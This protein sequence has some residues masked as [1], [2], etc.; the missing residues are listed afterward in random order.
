MKGLYI[1]TIQYDESDIG[2]SIAHTIGMAN[3]FVDAGID[4]TVLT[5]SRMEQLRSKQQLVKV[6]PLGR[7][8]Y[9]GDYIY[10]RNFCRKS[11]KIIKENKLDFDFIYARRRLFSMGSR[12]IKRKYRK[13]LVLEHNSSDKDTLNDIMAEHI[14]KRLG[15][16]KKTIFALGRPFLGFLMKWSENRDLKIADLIVV[17]SDNMRKQLLLE[18]VPENKI[19]VLPNAADP[20]VFYNDS[21]KGALLRKELGLPSD[22]VVVGFSGTFG[23]WHGIPE[24]TQAIRSM[25]D[26]SGVSF[27]LIGDGSQRQE[28]EAALAHMPQAVFTGKVPFAKMPEYLSACDVLV[29]S[30]SW[31]PKSDKPF[32]GSP[33]KLFEYLAMGKAVVAADLAQIGE[34]LTHQENALLFES[35]DAKGLE[36]AMRLAVSD[37]DLRDRL[38]KAARKAAVEKHTWKNN[39]QMIL[40]WLSNKEDV[41]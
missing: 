10:H 36:K 20:S 24:L 22:H 33:T 13:P 21:V 1:K 32:I 38:G 35:S 37:A 12:V 6:P 25:Q 2:G 7:P 41:R 26:V 8:N 9:I 28:M 27:L 34:I 16:V 31:S 30:N 14:I 5:R 4:L 19:M 18:G 23:N 17:V 39:A 40:D 15:I 11:L 3:G 29:V